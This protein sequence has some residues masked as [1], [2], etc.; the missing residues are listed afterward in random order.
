M[1]FVEICFVIILSNKLKISL[2]I[3][4]FTKVN[5]S[6]RIVNLF[7]LVLLFYSVSLKR[8]GRNKSHTNVP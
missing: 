8:I 3:F 1:Y 5:R 7:V 4:C 2:Y 6:A